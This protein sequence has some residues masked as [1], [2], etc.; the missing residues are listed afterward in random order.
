MLSH[1]FHPNSFSRCVPSA[2]GRP[3]LCPRLVVCA[4]EHADTPTC[5]HLNIL[6]APLKIQSAVVLLG[7]VCQGLGE[8]RAQKGIAA[9]AALERLSGRGVTTPGKIVENVLRPGVILAS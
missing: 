5:R 7:D 8:V 4:R 1:C 2:R 6:G 3:T 9:W